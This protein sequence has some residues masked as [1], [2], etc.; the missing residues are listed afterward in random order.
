MTR[1]GWVADSEKSVAADFGPG[2]RRVHVQVRVYV[3]VHAGARGT[4]QRLR[5]FLN[6][7]TEVD[8]G[9]LTQSA[10]REGHSSEITVSLDTVISSSCPNGSASCII[11]SPPISDFGLICYS[12]REGAED[13]DDEDDEG[14]EGD[15]DP[16]FAGHGGHG[17]GSGVEAGFVDEEVA[18]AE[19]DGDGEKGDL[20]YEEAAVGG[21]HKGVEGADEEPCIDEAGG[22][23]EGDGEEA[24]GGEA[25]DG[26]VRGGEGAGIQ[27]TA[28]EEGE[29]DE[30]DGP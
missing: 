26:G 9:E 20:D 16:D 12:G 27:L 28:E 17:C 30:T 25:A 18:G 4:R 7:K 13:G 23:E 2:Q 11:S 15:L 8:R 10:G 24:E 29:G 5:V 19:G 6:P 14:G 21:G 22:G 1:Y 3:Q